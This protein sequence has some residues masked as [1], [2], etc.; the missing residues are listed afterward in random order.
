MA[1]AAPSLLARRIFP[2]GDAVEPESW[3]GTRPCTPDM[4]P[5]I[6]PA[7][8]QPHLWCAFGH[9]HQGFTLGPT[10]G[11]LMAEM[12]TGDAPFVDTAPFSAER[13]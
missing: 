8:G 2:V 1:R 12:M 13:F 3:I 6:G 4:L 11:R 9:A 10:T 7:P 5:I